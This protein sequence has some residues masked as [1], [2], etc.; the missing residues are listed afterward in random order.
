MSTLITGGSG[1]VAS[2]LISKLDD[3]LLL[4]IRKPFLPN[5][6]FLNQDI[7]ESFNIEENI[8]TVVH[9]AALSGLQACNSDPELSYKTNVLGTKNILEL[10]RKNDAKII[11][12]S[13]FAVYGFPNIYSLTK[14]AGEWL[15][16]QYHEKY[17]VKYSILRF[18]N[19][20]GENFH[21]KPVWNVVHT[22][23]QNIIDKNSTLLIHG[24]GEQTRDF[25]YVQD[26][27]EKILDEIKSDKS[28]IYD[29]CTT[30]QNSINSFAK[31]IIDIAVKNGL[32]EPK[33]EYG[34][35]PSFRK[36]T[37]QLLEKYLASPLEC[38]T[39]LDIGLKNTFDYAT[40][41]NLE[42]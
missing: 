32:D 16:Q 39:S 11:F 5:T 1:F 4:D 25:V 12:A 38:K 15:C 19:V 3:A 13:S 7:S 2:N 23:I 40:Q 35:T 9:L 29:V 10:C 41:H 26:L 14:T 6:S 42:K 8:D 33:I 17:G 21:A 36:E 22:F 27:V 34:P 24:T 37:I 18:A 31:T 20:Y 30:V 28:G